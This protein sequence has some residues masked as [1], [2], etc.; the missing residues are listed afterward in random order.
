MRGRKN[1]LTEDSARTDESR[2]LGNNTSTSLDTNVGKTKLTKI[3]KKYLKTFFVFMFF[4][5][6]NFKIVF[7]ALKSF[8]VNSHF[9]PS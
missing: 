8:F 5:I 7:L 3:V 4:A 1:V 2:V 6:L 9:S